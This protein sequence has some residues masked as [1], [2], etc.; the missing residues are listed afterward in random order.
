[1]ER[2]TRAAARAARRDEGL[3]PRRHAGREPRR[4]V[5]QLPS[6][7]LRDGLK[8]ADPDIARFLVQDSPER[9]VERGSATR[10]PCGRRR[11][12]R[13]RVAP[14]PESGGTPRRISPRFLPP[15]HFS[16]NTLTSSGDMTLIHAPSACLVPRRRVVRGARR[17]AAR[18]ASGHASR[19]VERRVFSIAASRSNVSRSVVASSGK[20]MSASRVARYARA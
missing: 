14:S 2:A 13:F 20:Q 16:M 17:Q 3:K 6:P 8:D 10:R 11:G 7:C 15:H 18:G 12:E 19:R 5:A 1:M 4:L 9:G